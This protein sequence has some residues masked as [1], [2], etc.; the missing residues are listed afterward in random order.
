LL[1]WDDNTAS[2]ILG[3][4]VAPDGTP[5]DT[6]PVRLS[7]GV[8]LQVQLQPAVAFDGQRFVISYDNRTYNSSYSVVAENL[9]AAMVGSAGTVTGRATLLALPDIL[10]SPVPM[11]GGGDG[12]AI[13]AT[14]SPDSPL[15]YPIDRVRIHQ[16]GVAPAAVGGRCSATSDCNSGTCVDGV[17]CQSAC[18]GG[19]NDCQA[20]SVLAGA[21]QNGVCAPVP[22]QRACGAGGTCAAGV[23]VG[24]V[25]DAGRPD[26]REAGAADLASE[27]VG[28]DR[29][30]AASLDSL[31]VSDGAND[32]TVDLGATM[33][34]APIPGH[35][36]GGPDLGAAMDSAPVP[37]SDAGGPDG[38][39]D[40]LSQGDARTA[41]ATASIDATPTRG[42]SSGCGCRLASSR[43]GSLPLLS[44]V[45]AALA[46]LRR[47]RG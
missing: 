39:A 12:R 46:L 36:A 24:E 15:G 10:L 3:L 38:T 43:T 6:T 13:F 44:M 34:S 31:D 21:A 32:G 17:C 25:V 19:A 42:S 27:R 1:A 11:V 7:P 2:G 26:A 5:I 14:V 47:R 23:C 33:D 29:D 4:R 18:A 22:D 35:D 9:V 40:A 45:L 37:G 30:T 8:A 41:D 20:C 28:A 16:L